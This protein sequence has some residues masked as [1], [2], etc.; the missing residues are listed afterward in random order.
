MNTRRFEGRS[1]RS[2]V[3]L[4]CYG[5]HRRCDATQS[6]L[7][8]VVANTSGT[9][10]RGL[11]RSADAEDRDSCHRTLGLDRRQPQGRAPYG[12]VVT[13]A[14]S[15]VPSVVDI[16]FRLMAESIP[17]IVWMASVDGSTW[18]F[19][20]Q[21]VAYTGCS[22]E[23]PD[24]WS[25]LSLTHPDDV[26]RVREAW[27]HS[28][29]TKTPLSVECRIRRFDGEYRWHAFK[30]LH[31]LAARGAVIRWIGTATDIDDAK[32][33]TA[34]TLTVLET[35][36]SNAPIGFAFVDRDYRLMRVN[37]TMAA[38]AGSTVAELLGH[39]VAALVPE[40]WPQI[41]PRYRA[42][43]ETGEAI[44]DVEIAGMSEI[45]AQS[46]HWLT[47]YYPVSLD[48]EIIGI[49]I[50]V[51][52]TTERRAAE[53]ARQQ[54]AAIVDGSGDAIF[55]S[56]DRRDGHQLERGRRATVRIHR[57]GDH[58][59]AGRD[60][61]ALLGRA[62]EQAEMRARLNA[63]GAAR[64]SRDDAPPQ[65]RQPWW[66]SSSPRLRRPTRRGT[67]SACR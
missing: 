50:V 34:E 52:D 49:A 39:T 30:S 55:G 11:G 53:A 35:V 43:I 13:F 44:L 48:D 9:A 12:A 5:A 8:V 62:D 57:R 27:E 40:L 65:G 2:L 6:S 28:T 58:R 41:E 7:R 64:T 22:A 56:T 47:S 23:T 38:I 1:R 16:D 31:V 29:W 59:S 42:V 32:R 20:R 33:A 66:R 15:N 17:H 3:R 21:G 67:W 61:R 18:Y 26:D 54:L 51:V 10:H 4:T 24:G 45:D 19:N 14:S 36:L 60:D 46:R 37:E 25:W 63:G